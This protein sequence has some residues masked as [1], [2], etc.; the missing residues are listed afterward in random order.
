MTRNELLRR[1]P[2]ASESFIRANCDRSEGLFASDQQCSKGS[3]LD[4][5][6][7]REDKGSNR[8]KIVFRI[9]AVRPA[10]WDNWHVKEIQ[11][12]LVHAGFLVGDDWNLLSGEVIS[13]K[14]SKKSEEKTEITII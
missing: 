2:N 6:A 8:L 4:S 3:P 5:V 11:D 12:M 14:V 10:D 13:E 7:Q 9:F 1:Y